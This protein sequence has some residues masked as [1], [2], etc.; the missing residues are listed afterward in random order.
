MT[1]VPAP[2]DTHVTP[3]HRPSAL[4]KWLRARFLERTLQRLPR[5]SDV[6]DLCCGYGFY[7][8][9][10]PRAQGVDGDPEAVRVLRA[11][12]RDVKLAN[13]LE[14]LPYPD[15][16]FGHVVAHDVLEHFTYEQL[17]RLFTDVHRILRPAGLFVVLVP[18]R[19]GYDYG[20]AIGVGHRLFVTAREIGA[21]AAGRFDV[22]RNHPE[23]LPRAVGRFFVHNKEVFLLRRR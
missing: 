13:V 6:L 16:S 2:E 4:R 17:E 15:A 8:D 14:G 21:L 22:V 5:T 10:N 23:P 20:V 7:F 3:S 9:I 12:G 11:A 1:G 19:R 18:N